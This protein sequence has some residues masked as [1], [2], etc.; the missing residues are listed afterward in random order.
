MPV[1]PAT[2]CTRLLFSSA[3]KT[4]PCASTATPQGTFSSA[5]VAGPPS[6]D[7]PELPVALP[8]TVY[9]FPAV[10]AIPRCVP[11]LAGTS[12]IRLFW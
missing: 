3:M 5:L 10:I 2:S 7:S 11:E 12:W 8:A 9:M 1:V 6:P 4:S